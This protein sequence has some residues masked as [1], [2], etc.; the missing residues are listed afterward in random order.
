MLKSLL[1]R[2]VFAFGRVLC[3]G[4]SVFAQAIQSSRIQQI[5]TILQEKLKLSPAQRKLDSHIHF[6]AQAVRGATTSSTVPAEVLKSNETGASEIS[7]A[8][9]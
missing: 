7:E 3:F 5:Q 2:S 8:P 9:S 6:A 1:H 4:G